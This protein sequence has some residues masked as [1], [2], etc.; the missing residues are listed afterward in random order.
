MT[1]SHVKAHGKGTT[2]PWIARPDQAQRT[3][4]LS[5]AIE[6]RIFTAENP[7][8]AGRLEHERIQPEE[9]D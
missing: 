6:P 2:K 8:R 3:T 4:I 1:D 7:R 9:F 5:F